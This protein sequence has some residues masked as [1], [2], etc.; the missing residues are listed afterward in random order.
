MKKILMTLTALAMFNLPLTA[1]GGENASCG[2]ISDA[3][4]K[5][6]TSNDASDDSAVTLGKDKKDRKDKLDDRTAIA[7]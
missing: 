4:Q 7:K 1:F 6:L 2:Q 5:V 3:R